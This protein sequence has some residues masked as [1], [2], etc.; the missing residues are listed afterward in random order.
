MDGSSRTLTPF[1]QPQSTVQVSPG[2]SSQP[3]NTL[4]LAAAAAA[5]AAVNSQTA[6]MQLQS[7]H[8]TANASEQQNFTDISQ[9]S[10]AATTTMAQPAAD[11]YPHQVTGSGGPTATAPFLRDFSLVAEAAKRAQMSVMLGKGHLTSLIISGWEHGTNMTD[12]LD[13]TVDEIEDIYRLHTIIS[14]S[15]REEY[16]LHFVLIVSTSIGYYHHHSCLLIYLLEINLFFLSGLTPED[17]NRKLNREGLSTTNRPFSNFA[18]LY[19]TTVPLYFPWYSET[20]Y[21]GKY[22]VS[23]CNSIPSAILLYYLTTYYVLTITPPDPISI[24]QDKILTMISW[25]HAG[26]WLNTGLIGCAWLCSIS[27]EPFRLLMQ[28]YTRPPGGVRNGPN[29]EGMEMIIKGSND[30]RRAVLNSDYKDAVWDNG[31][32]DGD[33]DAISR[34]DDEIISESM[35]RSNWAA[36]YSRPDPVSTSLTV[37]IRKWKTADLASWRARRRVSRGDGTSGAVVRPQQAHP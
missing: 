37:S 16:L 13:G 2:F 36:R 14:S 3:Q 33:N 15:I 19:D 7:Q 11:T 27:L 30:A 6:Q 29:K 34:V 31:D 17:Q 9:T 35:P 21:A 24:R 26:T 22:R 10:A 18:H 12:R 25:L 8:P 32:S 1:N 28:K 4:G 23:S 5:A 20:E